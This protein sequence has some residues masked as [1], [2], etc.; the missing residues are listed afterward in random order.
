MPKRTSKTGSELFIVDNSDDDWKVQRYLHDWCGLSKAIDVATGYFEI[1]GLLGLKDEWQKVDAIR[2]LMGDEV[3]RRTRKAFAEGLEQVSSRLDDSLEAEKEKND[4]LVGVP[5]IVEAIRS[6][7]IQCRMYRKDKFHAKTY[8]THARQEVVGSF[9]L[10]G[11]SNLTLPGITENVELNVQIAGTPVSVLQEWYEEHWDD[12]EDVTAEILRVMERHTREYSPFEVYV[13][14]LHEFCRGHRLTANEWEAASAECGGSRM[15]S[16][17]D[18]YQKEGYHALMEIARQFGGAFLCDGVGLGKTFIGLMVIERLVIHEGKRVALFVP[19]TARV[20]VWERELRQRLKHVGGTGAGVFSGLV[21]FNHTDLGLKKHEDDFKRVKELADVIVIDEAHHFRNPGRAGED[22][23]RPSRYRELLDL[24]EGPRGKK[25][26]FL[27]TATPVNNSLH[28]FR[29]MAELFMGR[30][31]DGTSNDNYFAGPLGI[32]SLRRHFVDMERELFKATPAATKATE[33]NL[34]EAERVLSADRVFKALVVQ[35]SRAY[36]KKSQQQQGSSVAMFPT[37]E[38]PTVAAYSVKRTYGRLLEMVEK[39]FQKDKPLF[40]LGLYYPLA[41]YIGPDKTV[42]PWIEGRQQQVCG[43]IRTQFLKRFESSAYAFEQSCN[44]LLLKLLAWVEKHSETPGEKRRL[45][46]WK[47]RHSELT[48]FV[49]ERQ[50]MLWG[51]EEEDDAEEDLITEEMLEQV[52]RLD[53][54]EFNVPEILNDTFSDL[55]Q[56][57]QFLEELR[58][59]KAKHDDKL[60]ALAKLLSTD[61]VLKKGKLL[62]FNEFADTARYLHCQLVD[63]GIRGVEQIDSGSKKSRGDVIRRFAPYYNGLSSGE[64]A[65]RG[66]EEI[67]VLISTDVLSEGLN[68]Q[69]ATRMINYDLHWNPV[70]I[71]QRIG[72]VDRR[73]NPQV[74]ERMLA[75]HPEQRP[76]RGKVVYWNFLPPE[77]LNELLTLYKRVTQKTLQISKTFGIEGRKLLTPDDDYEALRDFNESYEGQTTADEEIRLEL[78]RLLDAD[79]GLADRIAALPG[80]VFSGK[81]HP[82]PGTKAVFFCY[83]LPRPDYSEGKQDADLPW[84][85]EAGETRWYLYNLDKQ[86]TLEEAAEIVAAIRST[87]ETPR[88]CSIERATLS[89]IRGRI[90]KHIKNTFLKAMQ[91]P[92]YVKP[93]L[94]AWMELN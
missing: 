91:A 14:A 15:Y 78:Q 88:R 38:P 9:A 42:D 3:S 44:R 84:T 24:M 68:L 67:R 85:E 25:E 6:G 80:R 49:H 5:A 45:D 65:E 39:A 81:E 37:R 62:I 18:H 90:E 13:R 73:L 34:V 41:Y 16:V 92:G 70:R 31:E 72:R 94:K 27:L 53:R 55:D 4:F 61:R 12:A 33:T 2:I 26:V 64:L 30:K 22:G 71:M 47:A 35:R 52:E 60:E 63:A 56:I 19:K 76:L 1:G 86:T 50:M 21:V 20:D 87:P 17:L 93:I 57:V 74:E 32:H 7:K 36:V 46:Q 23:G 48:H 83:R 51:D 11:S 82:A 58:T 28:D 79:P 59:F 89:E 40:T 54:D 66:E 75:D 8:I 29:H 10:V 69:D 77:E 43:L